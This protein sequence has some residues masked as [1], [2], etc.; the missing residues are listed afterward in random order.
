MRYRVTG[1]DAVL[2][3]GRATL[4]E[5]SR[6]VGAGADKVA[7]NADQGSAYVFVR[8]GTSWSQQT[9]LT[10]AD[11]DVG[12]CFGCS[13]ALCGDTALI[14]AVGFNNFQGSAYIFV[15]SG[16]SWSQQAKLLAADGVP[17]DY[18]GHAV[19]ISGDTA[20]LGA[21]G[22][23]VDPNPDQGSA[24]V[25]VRSEATWSLQAKLLAADGAFSDWFGHAVG[26]S[27]DTA[28]V[29]AMGDDIAANPDQGSAY[30]FVRSGTEWSEQTQLTAADGEAGDN[31]G[32]SA[33]QSGDTALVGASANTVGE[34]SYQGSAYVFAPDTTAPTTTADG[35]QADGDSGWIDTSQTVGLSAT[36]AG[37]S[38]V[39]TT[40]YTLDGSDQQT[41]SAPFSVTGQGS[42]T[43]TYWSVDNAG[44]EET[45][46]NTGYVNIDTTSP[47]LAVTCPQEDGLYAAGL[48]AVSF[49]SSD[50]LSGL[51]AAA[52]TFTLDGSTSTAAG[53][54]A[55]GAS[56][57]TMSLTENDL[58]GN[59]TTV[60]RSFTVVSP[61]RAS[62]GAPNSG[63]F[64]QGDSQ[65]VSWSLN[66]AVSS[67]GSFRVWLKDT[68][69]GAWVR[70]T[71]AAAP[72]AARENQ[73]FYSVPWTVTQTAGTYKLWVY[74]YK[75]DGAVGAT[76]SSSST[77]TIL[78]K[79]TPTISAPNDGSFTVGDSTAV[80]WTLN[81]AA[82]SG[83]FR[84]WL[85]N[86]VSGDWVRITPAGSPVPADPGLTAYSVPWSVTQAAA[87]YRLWVYY[88]SDVSG[89]ATVTAASLSGTITILPK[90]TPTISAPNSGSFLRGGS[91][92][93]SWTMNRAVGSGSFRVW[94]KNSATG[95]WVRI[96]PSASPVA[97]VSGSLSYW[98]PWYIT[99][100]AGSYKL[101][102][103]Y[104][105][106][107]G[108]SATVTAAQS[109]GAIVLL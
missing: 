62:I 97:A 55:A 1:P 100:P 64:V 77:I 46:H 65:A 12:E 80:S 23:D 7:D 42:H 103:Y 106:D 39:A 43:L 81:R 13:V 50:A 19:A 60:A 94:L 17:W 78:P 105:S 5:K 14:G 52:R 22:D 18:F 61:L 108:G 28:L 29:G 25:F 56:T 9:Q 107:A 37:G 82:A 54:A 44:N 30:L 31:F 72:V 27:G 26:I 69:S 109:S 11:G 70:I 86:T 59:S 84:V 57:H 71:P 89:S 32:F 96:T 74:Y 34:N 4:R 68:T 6:L 92:A 101:W 90:P 93:V 35:L 99:Q 36:D 79:V 66:G 53:V 98:V 33:A 95:A 16:T 73:V 91:T 75:A 40:C 45:P 15:R 38:G 47:V 88:Y 51:N 67:N 21:E 3:R 24:Y 2:G 8:S 41:Y 85:K 83:S 76:A 10:A 102:V 20:L 49:A 63:T 104:Y 87:S 48:W 58:A